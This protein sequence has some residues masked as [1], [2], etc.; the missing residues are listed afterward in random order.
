[1]LPEGGYVP[2]NP[3]SEVCFRKI[4][5]WLR[6]CTATHSATQCRK[7]AVQKSSFMPMRLIAV[8][9]GAAEPRIVEYQGNVADYTALS[10]CWGSA[11]ILLT[12]TANLPERSHRLRWKHLPMVFRDAIVLTRALGIKYIWID[13]ICI[14]QD[15]AADMSR[16]LAQMAE[17]YHDAL[18][19]I[20]ADSASNADDR[21]FKERPRSFYLRTESLNQK[22]R[23]SEVLVREDIDHDFLGG[24][25]TVGGDWPLA[26]RGWTL[27]ERFLATRII[28]FSAAEVVWECSERVRCECKYM[29]QRGRN[30]KALSWASLRSRYVH[31]LDPS[32]PGDQTPECWCYIVREYSGR[33]CSRDYDR[34]PAI[35]GLARSF[36][37][38]GIGQYRAGVWTKHVLRMVSWNRRPTGVCRRPSEYTAP[39]WSWA[40]IIGPIDWEFSKDWD[41]G[42]SVPDNDDDFV[43]QVLDIQCGLSSEN[44]YGRVFSGH[45]TISSPTLTVALRP[46]GGGRQLDLDMDH[47]LIM[48]VN[49]P[50]DYS[51]PPKLG[52]IVCVFLET[53][54]QM[55]VPALVLKASGSGC[56]KFQRI[57]KLFV[58]ERG[59]LPKLTVNVLS[60]Y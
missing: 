8:G 47:T 19:V 37:K 31:S 44:P 24:A 23:A 49:Q 7:K 18:L 60:I 26:R 46:S 39:S 17:I 35:S 15:D 11:D 16:Q 14:V 12:T 57:G 28:H 4:S 36:G 50:E 25:S 9:T 21:L 3:L 42:D 45:L 40:S 59:K 33:L 1:M 51:E 53:P 55:D 38:A 6:E 32:T 5:S 29:D 43:A 56:G 22:R 34:L 54:T 27:Q 10:Y 48:D 2:S 41:F 20:S 58:H 52:S 30:Q 13:A